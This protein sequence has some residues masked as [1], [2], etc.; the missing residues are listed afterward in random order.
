MSFLAAV[1]SKYLED[2]H[3]SGTQETIVLGSSAGAIAVEAVNMD[4]IRNRLS[5]LDRLRDISLDDTEAGYADPPGAVVSASP[6][7]PGATK[8]GNTLMIQQ[9]CGLSICLSP[10]SSTG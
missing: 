4:K 1:R 10:F 2:L 8:A 9:M 7:T 6:S 3:G 5:H